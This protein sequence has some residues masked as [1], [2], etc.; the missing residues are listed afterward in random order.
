MGKF[1][2]RRFLWM[3]LVL[4]LVSVVTFALMHSV[5]GG[6]FSREKEVPPQILA[7]LEAKYNLDAPITQQYTD[8][9]GAVVVPRIT[10]SSWQ[11]TIHEDYLFNISLP[12][13]YALRWMN[14]G[15]S[16]RERNRTVSGMIA[17]HLPVTAQLG[18]AALLVA[19]AIGVPAGTVAALN[20]NTM[21]DYV[22]MGI[23]IVGVSVT[24]ITSAPILQYVF[25]VNLKIL[26]ISGWGSWEFMVLPAFALGFTE[27]AI[28]ARLTR[29]SLLQVLHEDYVRTARAKGLRESYVVVFHT[30]KNALI[31]V[32]TVL[33]PITAYLLT[34]SFVIERIF[35]IPGIGEAFITSISNRDYPLIMGMVL[36]FAFILVVSNTIVDIA[37]AWLDPRIR[38]D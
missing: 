4:F 2:F 16:F 13:G 21:Y 7:A 19:L 9:I 11:R 27:S 38:F 5:P 32:V 18:V 24:T 33:G 3:L 28:I 34:G 6:P 26:P 31:P 36:L 37:Y 20:R 1:I 15:P 12:G 22:G 25:G 8:Y 29:A 14:F 35:G 17:F 23:A 30:L 10:D